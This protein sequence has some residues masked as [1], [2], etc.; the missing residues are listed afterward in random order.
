M[1][2][3]FEAGQKWLAQQLTGHA[4]RSVVYQRGHEQVELLATIGKSSYQLDDGAGTRTRAQV[5]DYLIDTH[6]LVLD[7]LATLPRAGDQVRET[8]GERIYVYEVMALGGEAP[9]RY[10]DPFR[11][12]L[13]VHT[14]LVRT[15]NV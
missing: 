14:K 3:R 2:D 15:E 8:D 10:S 11:L 13:R 9:W 4:S 7:G 1:A 6:L 12:K 5:R